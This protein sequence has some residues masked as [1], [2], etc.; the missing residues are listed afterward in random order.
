M[1]MPRESYMVDQRISCVVTYNVLDAIIQPSLNSIGVVHPS[2]CWWN[3]TGS[4]E[5][6]GRCD[7]SVLHPNFIERDFFGAIV[8]GGIVQSLMCA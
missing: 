5:K 3:K 1:K 7:T 8:V 2:D 4:R 6:F